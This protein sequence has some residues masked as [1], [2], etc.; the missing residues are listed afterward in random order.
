LA[1][2]FSCK[3]RDDLFL[4][5]KYR[6]EYRGNSQEQ[7]VKRVQDYMISSGFNASQINTVL[8]V[9]EDNTLVRAFINHQSPKMALEPTFPGIWP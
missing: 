8:T 5:R 3:V 2:I 7:E 9:S 6:Q 4:E 1:I